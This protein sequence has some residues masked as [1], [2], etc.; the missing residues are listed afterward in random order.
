MLIDYKANFLISSFWLLFKKYKIKS[1]I[2]F[3]LNQAISF[4]WLIFFFLKFNV[5]SDEMLECC[6]RF[7][8]FDFTS[9]INETIDVEIIG[10]GIFKVIRWAMFRTSDI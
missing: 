8:N 4:I 10:I 3:I 7:V 2:I 1:T 9:N 5:R 6:V